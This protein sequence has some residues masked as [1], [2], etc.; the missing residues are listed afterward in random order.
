[1]DVGCSSLS[2]N[3]R[4]RMH[5]CFIDRLAEVNKWKM[6]LYYRY[7]QY[8]V[9]YIVEVLVLSTTYTVLYCT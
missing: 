7:V 5:K 8:S 2:M 3:G 9:Q 6:C 1:M 4:F